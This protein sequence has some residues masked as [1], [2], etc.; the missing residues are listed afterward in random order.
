PEEAAAWGAADAGSPARRNVVACGDLR[1]G[2]SRRA[3]RTGLPVADRLALHYERLRY[4]RERYRLDPEHMRLGPRTRLLSNQVGRPEDPGLDDRGL[5][6]VRLG[7]PDRTASFG[8]AQGPVRKVPSVNPDDPGDAQLQTPV[9]VVRDFQISPEC[10]H[11]N[12]S[13]AYDYPDV[14]RV[15][16]FSPLDGTTNWWLLENLHDVYRCGDP[17]VA[18]DPQT[19][20]VGVLS[21]AM[22]SRNAP[23]SQIAWLVAPDLYMSRAALDPD[24]GRLS[25][26][27]ASSAPSEARD[28]DELR[29]LGTGAL[30]L[31][32]E[33][34]GERE[35]GFEDAERALAAIPD[36]P[37]VRAD[38]P[39]VHELL[40]F[41]MGGRGSDR[42]RVWLNAI[43]Q[44]EP[45]RAEFLP[46]GGLRY[47]VHGIFSLVGEDGELRRR[48][49]TFSLRSPAE[50]GEEAGV[51]VWLSVDVPPGRYD[52]TVTAR[53]ANDDSARPVGN[54]RS[55]SLRV[56]S[57]A[58]DVPQLSDV[59]FAPDSGGAAVLGPDV[60]LPITPV[61]RT[62]A[63]GRAWLYFE[64]YGLSPEGDY[65]LEI[66]MEPEED[67]EPFTLSYRGG[68]P[69]S[70]EEA[71]R[72]LLRLE[73]AD[74]PPGPYTARITVTD[75]AGRSSLPHETEL[76]VVH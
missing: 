16:H 24:Y 52:Y 30:E 12:E 45:L 37:A 51:P 69:A 23:M 66:R 73:L 60:A 32:T 46:D 76:R 42:T 33:L 44:G 55:E 10:Y 39:L 2:W 22:G 27:I 40:Q 34:A 70:T 61:H 48:E 26:E 25:H 54:W 41:R 31:Q 62:D 56:R 19:G 57:Y 3:A 43:V 5:V 74:S 68:A 21:P 72:R 18:F 53:D 15:F 20:V 64:A 9:T 13:W 49:A 6:Y 1:R 14:T 50:L 4:A 59:A 36:R 7:S 17:S 38:V 47:T 63:A 71:V 65:D 67:G 28:M 11:P 58:A 29:N 35:A 8:G 75:G